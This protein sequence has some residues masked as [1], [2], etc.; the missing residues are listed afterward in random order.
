M[1]HVLPR[2]SWWRVVRVVGRERVLVG[3]HHRSARRADTP[4]AEPLFMQ[5][6]RMA[7]EMD[8]L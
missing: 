8:H 5:T 3:P 2:A 1:L 6:A 4:H 7:R